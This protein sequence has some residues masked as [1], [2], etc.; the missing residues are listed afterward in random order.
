MGN[1][2]GKFKLHMKPKDMEPTAAVLYFIK[3]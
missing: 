3:Q 2:K 1:A